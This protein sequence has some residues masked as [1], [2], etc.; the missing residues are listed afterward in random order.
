MRS[1]EIVD[2]LLANMIKAC[3][4]IQKR[5]A[6]IRSSDDFLADEDGLLRLD[7]ICMQ[8]IAIGE[9]VK[10]LDKLTN[11]QLLPRYK[12]VPWEKVAGMR[13]VLAHHYFDLNAEIVFDVCQNHL[14]TLKTT[15][16][17]M[18]GERNGK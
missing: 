16:E 7:G 14:H 12:S 5:A 6:A 8:L 3:D 1:D 17:K 9:A 18:K 13:D 10:E 11:R 4:T 15:L 2:D